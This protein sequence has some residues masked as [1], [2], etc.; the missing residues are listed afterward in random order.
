MIKARGCCKEQSRRLTTSVVML[1][2]VCSKFA[3]GICGAAW[4]DTVS[5]GTAGSEREA[6]GCMEQSTAVGRTKV[7]FLS[8]L[9]AGKSCGSRGITGP[10][11]KAQ[12][13]VK[14]L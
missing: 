9:P 4:K 12:A 5:E 6:F 10:A 7:A 1:S 14:Q 8:T 11:K 2:P 3:A 13:A